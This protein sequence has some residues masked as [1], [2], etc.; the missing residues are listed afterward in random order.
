ML[1]QRQHLRLFTP[2]TLIAKRPKN[3]EGSYVHSGALKSRALLELGGD[4]S[5]EKI[6]RV[7]PEVY[8]KCGE[9]NGR[10]LL[11]DKPTY[12]LLTIHL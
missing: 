9:K 11:Q 10:A 7:R 5:Q 6:I 12:N 8:A 4:S 1:E 2:S 3:E